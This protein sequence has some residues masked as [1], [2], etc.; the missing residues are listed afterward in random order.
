MWPQVKKGLKNI[1]SPSLF[2]SKVRPYV[3]KPT[4]EDLL[5]KCSGESDEKLSEKESQCYFES[6]HFPIANYVKLGT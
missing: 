5:F 2:N 4:E 1:A 3:H 6:K